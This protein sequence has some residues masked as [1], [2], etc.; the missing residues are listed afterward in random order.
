[1]PTEAEHVAAMSILTQSVTYNQV[2]GNDKYAKNLKGFK[3]K[4]DNGFAGLTT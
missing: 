1:M 3:E 4:Y 2:M